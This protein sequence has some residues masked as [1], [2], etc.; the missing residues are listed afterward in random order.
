MRYSAANLP[1]VWNGNDSGYIYFGERP[2]RRAIPFYN[3]L[4]VFADSEIWML[5]GNSP[6]NFGKLRLSANIGI[7]APM[8]LISIEAGVPVFDSIKVVLAWIYYDGLWMFD[9]V[10]WWKISSPDID[11]FFDPDHEDYINPSYIDQCYGV[12]D[13]ETQCAYWVVYSGSSQTTPN[14]VIVLHFPTMWYGIYSY[15]TE[16]ASLISAINNR[17]YL[18]GGG[19]ACGKFYKLNHGDQDLDSSG[20]AKAI[21]AYI[22]TKDMLVELDEGTNQREFTIICKAQSGGLV[23]LDEYPDGSKTPQRVGKAPLS[24]LGKQ[25]TKIPFGLPKHPGAHTVKYRIRNQS[26]GKRLDPYGYVARVDKQRTKE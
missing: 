9:G 8:S 17:Y 11:T 18:C 13:F 2:L 26:L 12:Y 7:A 23:E 16:I 24:A 1:N 5:Q 6:S 15:G 3:E 21:D 25:H 4:V 22:T 10:K 14:K 19:N 20:N